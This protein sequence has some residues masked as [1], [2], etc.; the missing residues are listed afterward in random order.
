MFKCDGSWYRV[1]VESLKRSCCARSSPCPELSGTGWTW[2]DS[3]LGCY[4][5]PPDR[6]AHRSNESGTIA[7]LTSVITGASNWLFGNKTRPL[8]SL[9]TAHCPEHQHQP[10]PGH[11]ASSIQHNTRR[12][13]PARHASGTRRPCN[14]ATQAPSEPPPRAVELGSAQHLIDDGTCRSSAQ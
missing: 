3:H 13:F 12:V 2:L 4:T 6:H 8:P 5:R 9:A 11:T 7:R 14:T 10:H 1:N